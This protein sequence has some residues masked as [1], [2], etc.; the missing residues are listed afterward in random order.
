MTLLL[1]SDCNVL[2][3]ILLHV[4][5]WWKGMIKCWHHITSLGYVDPPVSQQIPCSPTL[6]KHPVCTLLSKPGKWAFHH[7]AQ[8]NGMALE[9]GTSVN[10]HRVW[11]CYMYMQVPCQACNWSF[12]CLPDLSVQ[13]NINNVSF[14]NTLLCLRQIV[15]SFKTLRIL[16]TILEIFPHCINMGYFPIIYKIFLVCSWKCTSPS[17]LVCGATR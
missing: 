3:T 17:T 4:W 10:C 13:T 12:A 1:C 9:Q 14:S 8:G 6:H 7:P 2:I 16:Y 11:S 15:Q 5:N